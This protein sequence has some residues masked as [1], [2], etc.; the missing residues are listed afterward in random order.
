MGL[1]EGASG[2][3]IALLHGVEERRVLVAAPLRLLGEEL[4]VVAR[5]DP[6]GLAQVGEQARRACRQVEGPVEAAVGG[7]H[8]VGAV[9][10]VGQLAPA[11]TAPSGVMR[12]VAS[13]AALPASAARMAKLSTA[14][15]GVMPTTAMPLRG[16]ITTRPS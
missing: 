1:H 6:H 8:V 4:E 12:A 14:S 10:G 13:S 2:R 7:D 3:C 5:H 16:V 11:R 9:D 15:C